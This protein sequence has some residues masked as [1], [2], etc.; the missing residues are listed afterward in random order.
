M[1][2]DGSKWKNSKIVQNNKSLPF[3][4]KDLV[5]SG[6]N[7]IAGNTVIQYKLALVQGEYYQYGELEVWY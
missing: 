3:V 6:K 2:L 1:S 5:W 7:F 4:G